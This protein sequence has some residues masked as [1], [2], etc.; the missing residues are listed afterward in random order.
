[1]ITENSNSKGGPIDSEK[2]Y[3]E[4]LKSK[5]WKNRRQHIL[6][7]D[8]NV[9]QDC[10]RR[11]V[12][13]GSYFRIEEIADLNNLLPVRLNGKDLTT[14][15][16]ELYWP[17]VPPNALDAPIGFTSEDV[18]NNL[19]SC[20]IDAYTVLNH[21][22]FVTDKKL[23]NPHYDKAPINISEEMIKLSFN[24]NKETLKGRMFA[25]HF[26]ENISNSNFASIKHM[27]VHYKHNECH[28]YEICIVI[29]NMLYYLD[30]GFINPKSLFSFLPLHVHHQYYIKGK[31]PWDYDDSALI[32]LCADCH[33]KRHSSSVPVPL[34]N[35]DKS[36]ILNTNIS[37]CDRCN[38]SGYLP[39][40]DYH[41][42]GICFK[43]WGEVVPLKELF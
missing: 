9:C 20:S 27:T 15:C 43:C 34:Y 2:K 1:M 21:F 3:S 38:G 30:F 33:Q 42:D 7:R 16:D 14:F 28:K 4:L 37:I 41:L 40:Y 18:G 19:Y 12:H 29:E 10:H 23:V 17:D 22:E 39:E 32:T 31:E 36:S 6:L 11:G 8:G 35:H 25:F 13:N 26:N 24:E 5:H